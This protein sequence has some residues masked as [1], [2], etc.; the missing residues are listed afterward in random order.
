MQSESCTGTWK[1]F[2]TLFGLQRMKLL[3]RTERK[4]SFLFFYC[5]VIYNKNHLGGGQ[6]C[7][8]IQ[9]EDCVGH[10]GLVGQE[11]AAHHLQGETQRT[12]GLKEENGVIGK[13]QN[14]IPLFQ[15]RGLML[16]WLDGS[17]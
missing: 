4:K 7:V 1:E 13:Q 15:Q 11:A 16:I 12:Q 9:A 17:H 10:Y 6:H 5:F 3:S 2:V 14:R 8:F